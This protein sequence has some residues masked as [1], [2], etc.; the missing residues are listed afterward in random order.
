[1]T[2]TCDKENTWPFLKISVNDEVQNLFMPHEKKSKCANLFFFIHVRK[3]KT[4]P[5]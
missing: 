3:N 2:F 1:M 5:V 4:K